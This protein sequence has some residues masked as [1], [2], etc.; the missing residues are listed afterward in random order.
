MKVFAISDLHLSNACDKPM[1]IFG[2]R[3]VGY[4]QKIERAWRETVSDSDLVLIAGDISWAMRLDEAVPDLLWVDSL[5]GK[6]III[7]GNHEYWWKSISAVREVLPASISAI[8]NDAIRVNGLVVCGTRG[9]D[10]PE[11]NSS[12]EDIKIYKREVERLKLSLRAA[13]AIRQKG[14]RLICMLHFPPYL[15]NNTDT[16][17]TRLLSENHVDSLV[18]GHIHGKSNYPISREIGGVKYFFSSCDQIDMCPI[19]IDTVD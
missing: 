11:K 16:D 8:Q 6:K 3:W 13:G 15:L 12:E 7:K 18:F 9:W 4:T 10:I 19:L 1:D 2:G 17:F 14:D 5:P